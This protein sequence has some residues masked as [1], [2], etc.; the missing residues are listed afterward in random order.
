MP[1][2]NI[3]VIS[4]IP[5]FLE[6]I[7]FY[8]FIK[9]N[10]PSLLAMI[11]E[12]SIFRRFDH[13]K[14]GLFLWPT[15]TLITSKYISRETL[16]MDSHKNWFGNIKVFCSKNNRFFSLITRI[17]MDNEISEFCRKI[18]LNTIHNGI[19]IS[20]IIIY[21]LLF[22]NLKLFPKYPL[23]L[24]SENSKLLSCRFYHRRRSTEIKFFI[25]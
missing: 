8:L 19:I 15:V 18:G 22:T 11:D 1:E 16:T 17:D 23:F 21:K 3:G 10:T 2:S 25:F 12:H 14:R 7:C 4:I 13:T 6:F 20:I 5:L 24:Y 9:T